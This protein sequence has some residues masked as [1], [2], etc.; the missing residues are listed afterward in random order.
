MKIEEAISIASDQFIQNFKADEK[1]FQLL[2]KYAIEELAMSEEAASQFAK[3]G[4]DGKAIKELTTVTERFFTWYYI[5]Y[6]IG[7]PTL[8]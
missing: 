1:L 3:D 4:V 2:E 8:S 5:N 7:K 6:V